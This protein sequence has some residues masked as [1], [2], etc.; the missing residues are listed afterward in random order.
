MAAFVAEQVDL[1]DSLLLLE[2]SDGHLDR[3]E[4][5]LFHIAVEDY[6]K[7]RMLHPIEAIG[8]RISLAD[9]DEETVISRFSFSKAQLDS[10]CVCVCVPR[11]I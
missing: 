1:L 6:A 5:L 8:D 2:F 11:F 3:T 10:V 4:L 9:L 7:R